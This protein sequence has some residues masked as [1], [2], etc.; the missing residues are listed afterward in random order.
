MFAL[1]NAE[2]LAPESY[3]AHLETDS[4]EKN[5]THAA[6]GFKSSNSPT[7]IEDKLV[8]FLLEAK[9]EEARVD[10]Q[11]EPVTKKERKNYEQD[12][13]WKHTINKEKEIIDV[14]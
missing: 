3:H 2:E 12:L 5:P 9:V 11:G 4:H 10:M 8:A 7:M 6:W 14:L 13:K 1:S